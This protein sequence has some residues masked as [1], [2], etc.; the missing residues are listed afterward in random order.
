MK[1]KLFMVGLGVVFMMNSISLVSATE[2]ET[3][4]TGS[5]VNQSV[6]VSEESYDNLGLSQEQKQQIK[7][8]L[9]QRTQDISAVVK[10]SSLSPQ[11]KQDRTD[12]IR[13]QSR[14]DIDQYLTIDQKAKAD[15]VRQSNDA[16]RKQARVQAENVATDKKQQKQDRQQLKQDV[17]AGDQAGVE[18]GKTK[19]KE[20]RQLLREDK[21]QGHNNRSQAREQRRSRR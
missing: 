13:A 21:Q 12:A 2:N 3:Q 18:A 19:L 6:A 15:D 14:T 1:K 8:L 10:D 7:P 4:T 17:Q 5:T 11:E 16:R 9:E 20:D